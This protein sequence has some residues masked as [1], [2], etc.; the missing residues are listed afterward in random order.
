MVIGVSGIE[1]LRQQKLPLCLGQE[2]ELGSAISTIQLAEEIEV[3]S[4][5]LPQRPTQVS[6][7][8]LQIRQHRQLIR[9]AGISH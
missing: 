7:G 1:L 9:E 4:R 5:F 3:I 6:D 8:C 2:A